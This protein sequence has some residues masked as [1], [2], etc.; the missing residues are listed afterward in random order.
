MP[1]HLLRNIADAKRRAGARIRSDTGQRH[2]HK[3]GRVINIFIYFAT[4]MDKALH[5]GS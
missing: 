2:E 3:V 5:A 4:L 1:E